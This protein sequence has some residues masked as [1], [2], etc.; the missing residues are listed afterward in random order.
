MLACKNSGKSVE[1]CFP[2]V[3]KTSNIPKGGTKSIIDYELTRYA[4]YLIVQNGDPRKEVIA[5][6]Q[7]KGANEKAKAN[8]ITSIG[9]LIQ[10]ATNKM[11]YPDFGKKTQVKGSIWMVSL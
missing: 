8:M 11:E 2:E 7:L 5:L 10:I 6:G 9:E 1:E 3:R 4:R